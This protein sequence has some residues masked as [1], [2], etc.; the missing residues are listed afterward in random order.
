[1]CDSI[2][3]LKEKNVDTENFRQALQSKAAM[4]GT[5]VNI[6]LAAV[7]EGRETENFYDIFIGKAL[8]EL[9]RTDYQ[10]LLD[11]SIEEYAKQ[12]QKQ[13]NR[14]EMLTKWNLKTM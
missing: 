6:I 3:F 8:E 4:T 1:M 2:V 9:N 13:I 5:N 14:G 12:Q 7:N 10:M 11:D